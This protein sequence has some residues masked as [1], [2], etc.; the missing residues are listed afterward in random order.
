MRTGDNASPVLSFA[1]MRNEAIV[2]ISRRICV[3][4]DCD[5]TLEAVDVD[6]VSLIAICSECEEEVEISRSERGINS[7]ANKFM[8]DHILS[9]C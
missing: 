5:G 4:P 8:E 7:L 9:E 3:C 1:L 2:Q 6:N